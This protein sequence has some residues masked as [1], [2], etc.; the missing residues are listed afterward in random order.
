M[1]DE[2][3]KEQLEDYKEAFTLFNQVIESLILFAVISYS[4]EYVFLL[5]EC[6]WIWFFF[7]QEGTITTSLLGTIMRSLGYNPSPD[8][9]KVRQML[10][11]LSKI[12]TMN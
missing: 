8:E 5:W 12:L 2:L 6:D 10:H 7:W 4:Y 1:A 11:D 9:L 3:T